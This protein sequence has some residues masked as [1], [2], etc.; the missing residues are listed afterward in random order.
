MPGIIPLRSAR[1]TS[2]SRFWL[3]TSAAL[4]AILATLSLGRWQLS[5][6]A[7]KQALQDAIDARRTLPPLPT[8]A[9]LAQRDEPAA[10]L[11][12]PVELR[13]RFVPE[14]TVFLDNRQMHGRPG[15]YVVTPL[16]LE[17]SNA[18]VL[19][20]RGWVARN[21]LDRA[22]LPDIATPSGL[23]QLDGRIAPVPSKLFEFEG[24]ERGRI[25]QNLDLADYHQETRLDLLALSVLQTAPAHAVGNG[26]SLPP[27][28]ASAPAS[29]TPLLRDWPQVGLGIE[30]HYGYAFQWF[31]LSILIAGLYL[32]HQILAPRRRG[33]KAASGND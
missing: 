15:F 23:V 16:V 26:I 29:Q 5:R 30:T 3:I 32:W 10:L 31:G 22:A 4:L 28:S 19:V 9:V 20:Q 1:R 18:A 33:A 25:R 11:H 17:H 6:A 24:V 8:A 13:G 12:R 21:F 2:G 14:D 7:Q 27:A